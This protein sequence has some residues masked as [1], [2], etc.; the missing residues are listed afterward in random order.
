[1]F[2]D[3]VEHAIASYLERVEQQE[4]AS[5]EAIMPWKVLGRKWHL[6]RK[7]FPSNHRVQWSAD[8]LEQLFAMLEES[9]GDATAD[10]SNKTAVAW[11]A[12]DGE[13]LVEVQTKRREGVFLTLLTEP[14]R[15]ALGR[16]ADLGE[17]REIVPHRSGRDAVRF[18]LVEMT[19]AF[20]TQLAKL[21]R[22]IDR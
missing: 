19:A 7:G 10:W 21:L 15:I 16:I 13:P 20:R 22:G 1:E 5:P 3:F 11:K 9:L 2:R 6:S 14:G 12:A 17:E 18:K 8:V 4:Q